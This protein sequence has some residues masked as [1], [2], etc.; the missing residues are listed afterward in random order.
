MTRSDDANKLQAKGV[1]AVVVTYNPS[2]SLADNLEALRPQVDGLVIVD[3]ATHPAT[4]DFLDALTSKYAATLIRNPENYGIARA[5][6][7]GIRC[8][9][10]QNF[11]FVVLFDQDSTVCANFV[12]ALRRTYANAENHASVAVVAPW[13]IDR[14]S[15]RIIDTE[16]AKNG[17]LLCTMTSG[18]LM[19]VDTFYRIGCHD[20]SL[21]ID[22]VDIEWCQR[23]RR[24]GMRILEAPEARLLHSL[25]KLQYRRAFSR[26][27]PVL[28]HSAARRYYIERNRW[29]IYLH[30]NYEWRWFWQNLYGWLVSLVGIFLYEDDRCQKFKNIA[31]GIL[32][33]IR[34]HMGKRLEL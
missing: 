14:N 24:Q 13:F 31:R 29:Y 16:R 25:G 23:A 10:E 12:L 19:N 20:E 28:N 4:Q 3:N 18:C 32:D 21:F 22:Y 2:P 9:E 6:N 5:L 27:M 7:Q 15:G 30:G 8:A 17:D 11:E 26:N 1:C 34:G 33:A